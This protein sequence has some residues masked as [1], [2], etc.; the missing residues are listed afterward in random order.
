MKISVILPAYNVARYIAPAIE[1]TLAQTHRDFELVIVD[2]GSSDDTPNIIRAYAERD[3][4]IRAH[5]GM[6][7]GV[8]GALNH[9]LADARG[10][11]VAVM[12]GDDIMEPIRLER[13]LAFVTANPDLAVSSSFV[14]YIDQDGRRIGV[15]RSELTS[16]DAVARLVAQNRSIGFHH[17]AVMMRK[18]VVQALGGYHSEM[19]VNED[20]ELWTRIAREGHKVVVQPEF[21][22][23]YRIHEGSLSVKKRKETFL[24]NQLIEL[25]LERFHAGLPDMSV[26][27]FLAGL[28]QMSFLERI[29]HNR[30][31]WGDYFYKRSAVNYA[32]SN[33][34]GLAGALICSTALRPMLTSARIV[35]KFRWP[36]AAL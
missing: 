22:L 36:R 8:S 15:Y 31:L 28:D 9:A 21:L 12:H 18:S 10:E 23:S 6:H 25:N 4:R 30:R 14:Y 35:N 17:P 19:F 32:N 5:L 26:A 33:M 13:Q 34:I 11:W 29:G 20:I 16:C 27:E 3:A 7:R 2:D 24:L 1:S